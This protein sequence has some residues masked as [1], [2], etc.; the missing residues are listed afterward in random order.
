MLRAMA[1][2]GP[3][4]YPM[5]DH[6]TMTRCGATR[7]RRAAARRLPRM[8]VTLALAAAWVAVVPE[9]LPTML[10]LPLRA[11]PALASA[12]KALDEMALASLHALRRYRVLGNEYT[13]LLS[14]LDRLDKAPP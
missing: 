3:L 5:A 12:A 9:P 1:N 4:P 2:P 7:R 14:E 13:Q 8:P 10:V 6:P 11:E